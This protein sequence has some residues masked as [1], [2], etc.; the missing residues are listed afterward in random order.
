MKRIITATLM[1]ALLV[2][3]V[4][5]TGG[6]ASTDGPYFKTTR[7]NKPHVFRNRINNPGDARYA[8]KD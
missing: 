5:L 3:F 4:A 6:C 2:G 8:Q 1:F 7:D